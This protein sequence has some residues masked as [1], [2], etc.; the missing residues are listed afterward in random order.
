MSRVLE[1]RAFVFGAGVT[2]DDILP[3][4]YLDRSN[5]EVGAFAMSGID[6]AFAGAVKP[7]DFV[8]AGPNFGAGSGRESA[9]YALLRAGVAA[10]VAPSFGRL[11][12]RNAIN[13]GLP[14]L[15]VATATRIAPGHHLAVDL[16]AREVHDRDD[17]T[18]HAI[19]NLTGISRAVLEAGGI[20][21]FTRARLARAGGSV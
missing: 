7:G 10:V 14:A 8:V 11:F 21:P 20:V 13:I 5:D 1:G 6:P 4:R 15:I 3:G 19:A 18:R 2:T 17:G 16:E 12:F 9:P